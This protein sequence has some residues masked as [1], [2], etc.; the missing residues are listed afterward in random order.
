[1]IQ[2]S[3]VAKPTVERAA[4]LRA[5]AR[6]WHVLALTLSLLL[7]LASI[8]ALALMLGVTPI[9]GDEALRILLTGEGERVPRLVIWTLRL[10]RFLLGALAGAALALVGALFQDALG[11]PLAEPGLLGVA[12][13]ASL[14]VAVV[15]V[16]DIALPFG[17]LPWLAL[18]G[19]LLA[20]LLILGTTR[21][22]RDPVRMILV[23]A[24]LSSLLGALITICVMLAK[25]NKIQLLYTFLIGSLLGRDWDELALAAP[26]LLA[27]IPLGLLFAR[28]LNLLQL[29]DA[30]AEGRG[31][32]FGRQGDQQPEHGDGRARSV[33]PMRSAALR[34]S[35]TREHS[36]NTGIS[37]FPSGCSFHRQPPKRSG[38]LRSSRRGCKS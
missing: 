23:G 8:G 21:L 19:G 7:A 29:G 37:R 31:G 14:V 36:M 9:G 30:V 16:F 27:G 26:W 24:A 15:L 18:A 33:S 2:P 1:M 11:N 10:P 34:R 17:G 32:L 6:L 35:H 25:P 20:G 28:P 38:C 22:T 13:G 5:P 3:S 12:S 4:P